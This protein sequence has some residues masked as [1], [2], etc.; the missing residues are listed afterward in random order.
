[1]TRRYKRV[2]CADGFNMSV[3]ASNTSYCSPRNDEGPYSEVEVGFPSSVDR[4]LMPYA[5]DPDRL[6]DTVYGYVPAD[7]IVKCIEA[8]GGMEAGELPALDI[9]TAYRDAVVDDEY[10]FAGG[11][12]RHLQSLRGG[13]HRG[14]A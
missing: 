3:Q 14:Q 13:Q 4:I 7:K 10:E 9:L 12:R 5:E 8:H 2:E 1:M 11:V 6:T